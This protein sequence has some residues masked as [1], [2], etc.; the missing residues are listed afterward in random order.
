[1]AY[2]HG[3][4]RRTL[5]DAAVEVIAESGPA[6]VSLRELARRAGVSHAAPAHHFGDKAGLMTAL[7]AEGFGLLADEL[8]AAPDLQESGVAYIRF[9]TRNRAHFEVMFRAELYHADDPQVAAAATRAADILAEHVAGQVGEADRHAA[10]LAAWSL[11]HGFAALW[12][13]GALPSDV[14]TDPEAAARPVLK[15]LFDGR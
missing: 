15:L 9:A 3:D 10:R 13:G 6:A 14:G 7:A 4:L 1:M 2:H 12:L 11:V 8:A 5:L